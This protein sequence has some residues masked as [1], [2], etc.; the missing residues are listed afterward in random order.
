MHISDNMV[1]NIIAAN[2]VCFTIACIAVVLRFQAR[3]ILKIRY[4]ADDWLILAGLVRHI[5]FLAPHFNLILPCMSSVEA[6]ALIVLTHT[7]FHTWSR[8][9]RFP[10]YV[11]LTDA[12]II[13]LTTDL[14]GFAMD[15]GDMPFY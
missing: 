3:R 8:H 15:Q 2:V 9:L 6:Y 12:S 14:Q 4:E 1:P 13:M 11:T 10:R 7:V 5:F